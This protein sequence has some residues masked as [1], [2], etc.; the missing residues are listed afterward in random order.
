MGVWMIRWCVIQKM[1]PIAM[2]SQDT[3]RTDPELLAVARGDRPADL[4]I[5]GGQIAN[6]FTGQFEMGNVAIF[7][8]RIA[9]VGPE[10]SARETIDATG[11]I[12]APGFIDAHMHIESTMLLPGQFV[13]VAAPHGTTGAVLDPHEI[14]NVLG[15]AG[16]RYLMDQAD[17]LEMNFMWAISSCVPASHLET[18]GAELGVDDLAPLMDD[19]RVVALAEMMNYPGV[20][21]AF[22]PV[23]AKVDLGLRTRLVDGHCPGLSARELQAYIAAGIS[24]DHECTTLHEAHEKLAL[25]MRVYIREGSAARNL[26]ALLPAVTESTKHRFSFC[27]DDRH[28][29]DLMGEG[30]IDNVVRRAVRSGMN[31]VTAIQIATIFTADHYRKPDLGAIAPGRQADVLILDDVRSL[32]PV[33]VYFKGRLIARDGEFVGAEPPPAPKA[34]PAPVR[35]SETLNEA[36]FRIPVRKQGSKVRVIGMHPHQL[37][38]A[39]HI[40][41]PKVENGLLATDT[42]RD[43]LKLAVIERHTGTGNVG[44]GFV[45]GFGIKEGALASTVGHDSHNVAV[46]G[47]S[48]ADMLMAARTLEKAGGGQ[49]VVKGGQVLAVL[50]LPVAGLISDQPVETV[51]AQQRALLDAS[52]LI[53]CPIEDP[54]MPLSFLPLVVIPKLKLSDRG[55][56]DVEAFEHVSIEV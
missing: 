29:A 27:T 19:A 14:A 48:D 40:E 46:V 30:H 51:I 21:H 11:R 23:L 45:H 37:V 26:D 36:S 34:P 9:C 55:L 22:E 18:S 8:S 7:G 52:Q 1:E 53:G 5:K 54:F 28:P 25:G 38:T 10:T 47:T 13:R 35:L 17:G 15:I 42:R 16:I 43:I 50:P 6:V 32:R 4:L 31:P 49:C 3:K 41:T 44:L 56:V 12:V 24:S 39:E 33:M 2:Q 20:V